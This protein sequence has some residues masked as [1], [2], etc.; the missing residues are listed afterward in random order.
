M[1]VGQ[2]LKSMSSR[3]FAEWKAYARIT[4]FGDKRLDYRFGLLCALV[5]NLFRGKDTPSRRP[6]DFMLFPSDI[7]QFE[8][9]PTPEEK[10]QKL[11]KFF[12]FLGSPQGEPDGQDQSPEGDA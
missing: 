8:R 1:P 11:K 12:A 2:L 9:E 4:R 5:A 3:E 10:T 7:K 6:E